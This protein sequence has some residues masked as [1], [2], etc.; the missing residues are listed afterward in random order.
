MLL[1]LIFGFLR[2][3]SARTMDV[4]MVP[5]PAD[6]TL[7]ITSHRLNLLELTLL[8][9][10][11]FRQYSHWS[12]EGWQNVG[13]CHLWR[14]HHFISWN[15]Q[16]MGFHPLGEY[17]VWGREGYYISPRAAPGGPTAY[18]NSYDRAVVLG[19][20]GGVPSGSP[21]WYHGYAREIQIPFHIL[22]RY[23]AILPCL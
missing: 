22:M 16:L 5:L 11:P 20:A 12:G 19:Y 6:K 4:W 8:K 10:W 18:I 1:W 14:I 9:D 23:A 21:D 7:L 3:R 13:P 15:P 17:G 2:L